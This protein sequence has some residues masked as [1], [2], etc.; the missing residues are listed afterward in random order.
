M[1]RQGERIAFPAIVFSLSPGCGHSP[2]CHNTTILESTGGISLLVGTW[3]LGCF[4]TRRSG[5]FPK[6]AYSA[7]VPQAARIAG[8]A[9]MSADVAI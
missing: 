5:T 3:A 4:E 7:E 2:S 1:R 6:V 8:A 9:D